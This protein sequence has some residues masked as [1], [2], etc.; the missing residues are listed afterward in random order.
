MYTKYFPID[1]CIL[2]GRN[3]KSRITIIT[4]LYGFN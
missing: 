2:L 4:L 1:A 3:E